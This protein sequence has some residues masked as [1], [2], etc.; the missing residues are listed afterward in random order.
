MHVCI[1]IVY[2]D[3]KLAHCY[4]YILYNMPSKMKR[5][6]STRNQKNKM[7]WNK[8]LR[9]QT[10]IKYVVAQN[11]KNQQQQHKLQEWIYKN[12]MYVYVYEYLVES[13][14]MQ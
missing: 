9:K 5:K 13:K 1:L 4:F 11:K 14:I 12:I 6:K 7:K 2:V 3:I 8:R 10:F